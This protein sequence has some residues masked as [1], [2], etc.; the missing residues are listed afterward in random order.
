[1]GS[2][3]GIV[4]GDYDLDGKTDLAV[5]FP[6]TATMI[7]RPSGGRADVSTSFGP[8]GTSRAILAVG[9][10]NGGS[11][12]MPG[13]GSLSSPSGPAGDTGKDVPPS[14][15]DPFD[16]GPVTWDSVAASSAFAPGGFN[17]S[18][19][20]PAV[21]IPPTGGTSLTARRPTRKPIP[22][23][24]QVIDQS[25]ADWPGLSSYRESS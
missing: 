5:C 1:M 19:A 7:Y 18:E 8:T 12:L 6:S 4:Q 21:T 23:I 20:G 3:L 15:P 11:G 14:V 24:A 2:S 9:Q 13:G 10:L 16:G 17:A 25:L 22:R